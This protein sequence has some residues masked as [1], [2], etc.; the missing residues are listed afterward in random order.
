MKLTGFK[1]DDIRNK[2][3]EYLV[4]ELVS[5]FGF[6]DSPANV[7]IIDNVYYYAMFGTLKPVKLLSGLKCRSILAKTKTIYLGRTEK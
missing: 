7:A 1:M 5:Y 3:F 6:H 4:T 2:A